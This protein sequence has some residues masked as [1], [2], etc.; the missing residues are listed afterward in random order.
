MYSAARLD[1]DTDPIDGEALAYGL[2]LRPQS[3]TSFLVL[4]V[5]ESRERFH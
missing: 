2:F 4:L 1:T 5:A 3:H